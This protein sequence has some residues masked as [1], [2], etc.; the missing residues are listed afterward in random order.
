LIFSCAH[1]HPSFNPLWHK[2]D[3]FR[4]SAVFATLG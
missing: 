3:L 4:H 1:T 2:P